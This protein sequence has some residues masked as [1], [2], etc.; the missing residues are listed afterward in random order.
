MLSNEP[1][2][3]DGGR[4]M[5]KSVRHLVQAAVLAVVSVSISPLKSE[6][7]DRLTLV[8]AANTVDTLTSEVIVREAYRRIGID[9]IIKKAPGERALRMADGG[10]VAGDVQR[11]DNLSKVY[12]NLIQLRPAINYI[13]GSAFAQKGDFRID[14]WDSL[15]PHRLGIIRGIKFAENNTRGMDTYVAKDYPGLFRM[16]RGG[17]VD[18]AISPS[19]NGRY[20][21][22]KLGITGIRELKPAIQ[23]FD[24]FHYIHKSQAALKPKLEAV[25]RDMK[26]SG[27]L[28]KIRDHVIGVLLKRA[29]AGLEICDEDYACF[30]DGLTLNRN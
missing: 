8:A 13:E 22:Q 17:R 10:Q 6:A 9:L 7:A 11:I 16:L 3:A 12:K 2:E 21:S 15:R 24:L 26:A 30:E 23:R 14:G 28:K 27:E 1:A 18:I 29:A 4:G 25:F 20:Q 19:L 5:L